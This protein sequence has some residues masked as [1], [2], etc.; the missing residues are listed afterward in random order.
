MGSERNLRETCFSPVSILTGKR[1]DNPLSF[2][3]I[4]SQVPTQRMATVT[5]L[6]LLLGELMGAGAVLFLHLQGDL[7]LKVTEFSGQ[8]ELIAIVFGLTMIPGGLLFRRFLSAKA[9]GRQGLDGQQARY[10]AFL[11]PVVLVEA[12][13]LFAVVVWLISPTSKA[14]ASL[15]ALLFLATIYFGIT[16]IRILEEKEQ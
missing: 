10:A 3:S 2:F 8:L 7:P 5:L 4:M 9:A 13:C 15:T 12:A 1:N 6:A 14:A 16:G 11:I